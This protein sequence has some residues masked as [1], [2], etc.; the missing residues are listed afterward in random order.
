ME[1]KEIKCPNCGAEIKAEIT[2]QKTKCE[3]CGATFSV[4]SEYSKEYQ[5]TK[6]RLKATSDHMEEEFKRLKNDMNMPNVGEMFEESKK[7]NKIVFIIF[8]IIFIAVF[9]IGAIFAVSAVKETKIHR[10]NFQ[11]DNIAGTT[12]SFSLTYHLDDIIA[13]NKKNSRKITVKYD[14]KETTD[15]N[16]ILKIKNTID[17]NDFYYDDY[18]VSVDYDEKG[19]VSVI[20]IEK[21]E[22]IETPTLPTSFEINSFNSKFNHMSGTTNAFFMTSYFDTII[23]NNKTNDRKITVRYNNQQTEDPTEILNIK[24]SIGDS[25]RDKFEIIIDYDNY[26]FV[27]AITFERY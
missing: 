12:S 21:K 13:S 1:L 7:I 26:G 15:P 8:T 4:E 2:D 18:E 10:F 24:K 9:V 16:E 22:K 27:S 5:K 17:Q 23:T 3:Y 19:Y 11:F 25:S 6:G 14:G 20:T